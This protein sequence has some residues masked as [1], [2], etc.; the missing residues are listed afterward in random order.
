MKD[1]AVVYKFSALESY[2]PRQIKKHRELNPELSV[3]LES[4]H[5]DHSR[6]LDKFRKLLQ[7]TG[8]GTTYF[9]RDSL[10][11]SLDGYRVVVS[12]GGDGTFINAS[13]YIERSVL[14]G[15]N[16]SPENSVGH[17]CRFH[18]KSAAA[19]KRLGEQLTA[20]LEGKRPELAAT[21]LLRMHVAVQGR[22]V[23]FPVLNDILFT[24]ANPAATSRYTLRYRRSIHHQKSSGIWVSTPTG[25]T[26]AYASAGGRPFKQKQ[27]R[28]IVRELYSDDGKRLG[29]GS[30]KPGETL[31]IVCSMMNGVL[32]ADGSHHRVPVA[33]GEH[34]HI[35][36]HETAL[37]AIY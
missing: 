15:V 2:S 11:Q 19:I 8:A 14:V 32:F 7:A 9:E 27:L 18:L 31:G 35:R 30:V 12:F 26:A 4:A 1:I 10:Q 36:T 28:F 37:R 23:A 20:M 34:L 13:H 22:A 29:G 17:Y 25:S 21:Q 24:E 16:S 5:D 3:R 6:A 33:L